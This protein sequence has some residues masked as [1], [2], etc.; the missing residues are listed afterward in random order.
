MM[1]LL[2]AVVIEG[3]GQAARLSNRRSAGKTGTTDSYH[4]AWFV[5]FTTEIVVG[6]WL[7]NDDNSPMDKVTGGELPAKIWRDF[8]TD[9]EKILAEP[10][11]PAIGSS[12]KTATPPPAKVMK[13]AAGAGR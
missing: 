11:A 10:A 7:G 6:V 12:G 4:D 2:E 9:A 1:R 13:A 5:G 3:T 8:V